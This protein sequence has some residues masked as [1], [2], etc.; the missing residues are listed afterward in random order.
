LPARR[1][2]T[3]VGTDTS[4]RED[5]APHD[6]PIGWLLW[7]GVLLFGITLIGA[8]WFRAEASMAYDNVV[9][10]GL[11]GV[12]R[13]PEKG[14]NLFD[15]RRVT[16]TFPAP[17]GS[18]SRVG[19]GVANLRDAP[20]ASAVVVT[21]QR[22]ETPIAAWDIPTATLRP[23]D[24]TFVPADLRLTPGET[25]A[26]T[27]TTRGVPRE[28]ALTAF[29]QGD[30]RSFPLGHA[31]LLQ[32]ERMNA[33]TGNIRFAL[34]RDPLPAILL[35]ALF[36]ARAFP[37]VLLWG[38][39][40]LASL[41]PRVRSAVV[42]R[43]PAP[44]AVAGTPMTRRDVWVITTVGVLCAVT[45]TWPFY[46]SL[47]KV[48]TIG[49]PNR[50]L[51]LHGV[52]R[53]S[54]LAD[55]E[56]GQWDPY[57]C[58]GL[59]LLGHSE[60]THISPLFLP[61]LLFGE[62]RGLRL[63]T[64][65]CVALAFVGASLLA[66][67]WLGV[68]LPPALLAGGVFALSGF[69]L[70]WF[71]SG[72]HG[73]FPFAFIP[74]FILPLWESFRRRGWVTL[75]AIALALIAVSGGAHP[76]TYALI[77]TGIL[78][79]WMSIMLRS[80]RPLAMLALACLLAIPL[81]AIKLLPVAE[82]Q[83][84]S[85][86]FRRPPTRILPISLAGKM[87][88]ARDQYRSPPWANVERNGTTLPWI[89][90]ETYVGIIPVL[91]ALGGL[92]FSLRRRSQV[93]IAG[94][95]LVLFVMIF[96]FFPWTLLH[97]MPFLNEILRSPARTRGVFLLF[98]GL[99]AAFGLEKLLQRVPVPKARTAIGAALV[100][101]VL[102]DLVLLHR[103]LFAR[104]YTLDP[105]TLAH[106]S[107]FV[108]VRDSYTEERTSFYRAGYLNFLANEGTT[109]LCFAPMAARGVFARG[110]DTSNPSAPYQGEAFLEQGG[111]ASLTTARPNRLTVAVRP[112][113]AGWLVLNQNFY[114]GWRAL[115]KREIANRDGRLAVRI[116]PQDASLTLSFQS[117][118]Y[119]LGRA[120]SAVAAV[121]IGGFA[122][123]SRR[124]RR[125]SLT[126][127]SAQ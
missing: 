110:R 75:A 31:T 122:L 113:R 78:T 124:G 126:A 94:T 38:A 72:A 3:T 26:L 61:I 105:P 71:A 83:V 115:P 60:S 33:L 70:W 64:T 45:V 20:S 21:V 2:N 42:K 62:D 127:G 74:W 97:R 39:L 12:P 40:L 76:L 34:V 7:A 96:G 87:L 29:Y 120:L 58:G 102:I 121:L 48:T 65:L 22:E 101:V 37:L 108:R 56:L 90:Y 24:V 5:R 13:T 88:L 25:Y 30:A 52:A 95:A 11:T 41:H 119:P 15:G 1:H 77:A 50:A 82:T 123:A 6:A 99:L 111:D 63:T 93:P 19:I 80:G 89:E 27:V 35:D 59:P 53:A 98:F 32:D 47:G 73:F 43:F 8:L 44:L 92:A 55:R 91:A 66:R 16:Q 54:L 106:S 103:P 10:Q 23:D 67:R 51:I 36:H 84:I 28:R 57:A 107:S 9:L 49:D 14:L 116:E 46:A 104:L 109:D 125:T 86:D 17:V 114:P 69:L 85:K 79:T 18:T 100:I 81:S 118:S 68:S 112:Q 117:L 4:A